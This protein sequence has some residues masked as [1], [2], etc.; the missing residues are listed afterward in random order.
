MGKDTNC[1]HLGGSGAMSLR[2]EFGIL[3]IRVAIT[4]KRTLLLLQENENT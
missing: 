3:Y 1:H 2:M 4:S